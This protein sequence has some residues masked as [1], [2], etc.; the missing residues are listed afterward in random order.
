MPIFYF[1]YT[2]CII[3]LF[4]WNWHSTPNLLACHSGT[5]VPWVAYC[6]SV[7]WTLLMKWKLKTEVK[8][9]EMHLCKVKTSR[10]GLQIHGIH[11][12]AKQNNIVLVHCQY[13]NVQTV[14]N[15]RSSGSVVEI[16]FTYLYQFF[17]AHTIHLLPS[18]RC[19]PQHIQ[20][21]TQNICLLSQSQTN[22]AYSTVFLHYNAIIASICM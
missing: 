7:W 6:C 14:Q 19:F 21:S 2:S 22:V 8:C 13:S 10:K 9:A 1:W 12:N 16:S 15:P 20:C 18:M 11:I 3:M 5:S 17:L 4:F